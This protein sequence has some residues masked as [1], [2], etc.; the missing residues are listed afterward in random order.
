MRGKV[1]FACNADRLHHR[2]CRSGAD[3]AHAFRRL[4][5]VQLQ[6]I[7]PERFGDC[8][9]QAHRRRRRSPRRSAPCR[10]RASASTAARASET[11]R[12][13]GGNSMNPTKSAPAS[14]AASTPSSPESP[15][16]L[17]SVG[18]P[19]PSH[20]M[21]KKSNPRRS[22]TD[23]GWNPAQPGDGTSALSFVTS[24]T[25]DETIEAVE[26]TN[27]RHVV[28]RSGNPFVQ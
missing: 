20:E 9:E 10:G 19:V 1:A 28:P 7:R 25:F 2:T 16:I 23:G 17:I 8:A 12:G 3:S 14:S 4:P 15:Q 6:E 26:E 18:M 27:S 22:P 5:A 21:A 13:L 24:A 11:L